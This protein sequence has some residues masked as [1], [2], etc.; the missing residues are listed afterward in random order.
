MADKRILESWQVDPSVKIPFLPLESPK[1]SR[2]ALVQVIKVCW[3]AVST[4]HC[5]AVVVEWVTFTSVSWG[6]LMFD[7]RFLGPWQE[8]PCVEIPLLP[9]MLPK[10]SMLA[11]VRAFKVC[12]SPV[13]IRTCCF[14]F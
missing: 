13:L 14:K 6:L 9:S 4:R 2:L 3:S 7:R 11:L 10:V 12:W 5:C 1:E 8:D